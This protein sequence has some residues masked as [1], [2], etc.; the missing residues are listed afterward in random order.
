MNRLRSFLLM[1]GVVLVASAFAPQRQ[2]APPPPPPNPLASVTAF[3]CSFPKFV[4]TAW[5][6]G[7][8]VTREG[9]ETFG[10]QIANIN[11]RRSVA[12]IVGTAG[13][14]ADVTATLTSTGLNII[15]PTA[16]GN[17][18]L[19]TIF[20]AGGQDRAYRA[21]HSRHLGDLAA[22]PSVSQHFGTCE[23]MK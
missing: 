9:E 17:F 16:I 20:S 10:F 19:T 4:T 21:V 2:S 5:V 3:R 6:E 12:R 15:E 7:L 22:P 1:G 11:P 23:A 18:I 8:P 14:S 13:G